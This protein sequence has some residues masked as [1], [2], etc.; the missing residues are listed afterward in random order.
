IICED[1]NT[2]VLKAGAGEIWDDLV[3]FCVENGHGGLE[4]LS[5]IPGHTGA[6]PVQNIGAYGV[7]V[8]ERIERVWAVDIRT[9]EEVV[10]QNS[11]C[12]FGYRNSIFKEEYK[13]RYIITHVSFR[14]RKKNHRLNTHYGNIEEELKK[15]GE[16]S[17]GAIRQAVINIRR[18]K[19]PDPSDLGNAGSF[20]KNP[21][22]N[23]SLA[24]SLLNEYPDMPVYPSV[25]GIKLAAGRLIEQCGWKGYREGDAGVH[26]NQALV[27]V[28]HGNATGKQIFMLAEE[29]SLSVRKKFGV[30]LEAEVNII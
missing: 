26:S 10:F 15:L 16:K 14:L 23:K 4:N 19:L 30:H 6:T 18:S 11:D 12:R 17:I 20:F 27:L 2:I 3:A 25:T 29:I 13:G 8:K 21:V 5:L 22:V 24:D 1:N 7:E 28:N 9:S